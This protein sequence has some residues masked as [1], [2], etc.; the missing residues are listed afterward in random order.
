MSQNDKKKQQMEGPSYP[1]GNMKQ[2]LK[3]IRQILR[4]Q[5]KGTVSVGSTSSTSDTE[6]YTSSHSINQGSTSSTS[7]VNQP[8]PYN[9]LNVHTR[10]GGKKRK[11]QQREQGPGK[12]KRSK[13]GVEMN[14]FS[15]FIQ[16]YYGPN[17]PKRTNGTK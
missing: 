17:G 6:P 4:R 15:T 10:T 2:D 1:S 3:T 11:E 13:V 5:E 9:L 16:T 8:K 12:T 14:L 7:V